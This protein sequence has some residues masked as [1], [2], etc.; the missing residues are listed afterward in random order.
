VAVSSDEE[1]RAVTADLSEDMHFNHSIATNDSLEL[2]FYTLG[3]QP[4]HTARG[5]FRFLPQVDLQYFIDSAVT[6][7]TQ[8]DYW[9]EQSDF[10]EEGIHIFTGSNLVFESVELENS[11]LVFTGTEIW[12]YKKNDIRALKNADEQLPALVFTNKDVYFDLDKEWYWD[13]D[14]IAGAIYCAGKLEICHARLTGPVVANKVK[15][16][17]DLDF[18][19]E[20]GAEYYVWNKGFGNYDDYDWPKHIQNWDETWID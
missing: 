2:G 18:Y 1:T 10:T 9:F 14:I 8:S 19:D 11:T 5:E 3:A 4:A 12:F 6:I 15:V 16:V 13:S 20:Y 17:R 7:H